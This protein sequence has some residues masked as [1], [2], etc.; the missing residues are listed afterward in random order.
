MNRFVQR[1]FGQGFRPGVAEGRGG[2]RHLLQKF[3]GRKLGI[4]HF[5]PRTRKQKVRICGKYRKGLEAMKND[6]N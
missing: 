1:R 3:L 4:L 6:T 2:P 5:T